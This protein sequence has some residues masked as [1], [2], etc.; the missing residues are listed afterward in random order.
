MRL[1]ARRGWMR[2]PRGA[3]LPEGGIERA[4]CTPLG[5]PLTRLTFGYQATPAATC[6]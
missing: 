3:W 4:Y 2:A 5:S 1:R 6:C